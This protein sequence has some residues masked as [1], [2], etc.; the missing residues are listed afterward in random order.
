M[1]EAIESSRRLH[2]QLTPIAMGEGLHQEPVFGF[3]C[4]IE[5][6]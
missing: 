2:Q 4:S 3:G 6:T 5:N 1:K